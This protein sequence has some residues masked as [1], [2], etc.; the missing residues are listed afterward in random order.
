MEAA[1][2][3]RL[4]VNLRRDRTL[5]SAPHFK[6]DKRGDAEEQKKKEKSQKGRI[7]S[8]DGGGKNRIRRR[9]DKRP[10]KKKN[11]QRK[12]EQVCDDQPGGEALWN[13]RRATPPPSDSFIEDGGR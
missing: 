2:L 8:E 1:F 12:N 10:R 13:F 9:G 4:C 6:A 11:V 3:L 7:D 5:G